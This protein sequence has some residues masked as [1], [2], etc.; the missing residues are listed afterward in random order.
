MFREDF[1]HRPAYPEMS[2]CSFGHRIL[3]LRVTVEIDKAREVKGLLSICPSFDLLEHHLPIP[4]FN[5]KEIV[6]DIYYDSVS[7]DFSCFPRKKSD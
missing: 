2:C 4:P 1:G 3:L 5:S 7:V 6:T